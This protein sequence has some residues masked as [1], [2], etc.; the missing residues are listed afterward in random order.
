M[1]WIKKIDVNTPVLVCHHV[2]SGEAILQCVY[3]ANDGTLSFMCDSDHDMLAGL[4]ITWSHISHLIE[5][6]PHL[7]KLGTVKPGYM[8]YFFP[9]H[10]A[11]A[12][13]KIECE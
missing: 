13:E 11:W 1:C 3:H 5:H 10:D 9:A 7:S 6:F 2:I 8:G 12:I 4:D